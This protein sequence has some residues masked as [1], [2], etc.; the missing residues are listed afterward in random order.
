MA[1][2]ALGDPLSRSR[3]E[4]DLLAAGVAHVVGGE[5]C[6]ADG[7]ACVG[8]DRDRDF[9]QPDPRD[10]VAVGVCL[11]NED[12]VGAGGDRGWQR[13]QDALIEL[14]AEVEKVSATAARSRA[15]RALPGCSSALPSDRVAFSGTPA[16]GQ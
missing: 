14:A 12:R 2:V 7:P 10:I 8:C 4:R 5:V 1:V 13:R 15:C 9:G 16:A 11:Q 3:R 6:G